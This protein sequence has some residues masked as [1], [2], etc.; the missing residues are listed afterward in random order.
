MLNRRIKYIFLES[1][2]LNAYRLYIRMKQRISVAAFVKPFYFRGKT[3]SNWQG[4]PVLQ[5]EQLW[6]SKLQ[7][8]KLILF[9]H[10]PDRLAEL[11]KILQAKG[12]QLGQDCI[13]MIPLS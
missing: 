9:E 7:D 6:E 11:V 1:E 12:Q 4:V 2:N 10:H 13:D 5:F 8:V 3:P